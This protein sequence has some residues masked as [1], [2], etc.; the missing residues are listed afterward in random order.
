[1]KY[2]VNGKQQ[3]QQQHRIRYIYIAPC[4]FPHNFIKPPN[5]ED[6]SPEP[7]ETTI[8]SKTLVQPQMWGLVP[9]TCY[10]ENIAKH[11]FVI[12]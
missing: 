4:L 10:R 1:M 3:Q 8:L 9:S 11:V 6:S 5:G 7:H 12:K 2:E